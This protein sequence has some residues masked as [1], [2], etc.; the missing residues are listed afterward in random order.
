[1]A[2]AKSISSEKHDSKASPR[3]SKAGHAGEL[4][5]ILLGR[6]SGWNR[7]NRADG[8]VPFPVAVARS[9]R[10]L[11]TGAVISVL[12]IMVSLD[13]FLWMLPIA[14]GL[15]LSAPLIWWTSLT[16]AGLAARRSW[17]FLI[18]EESVARSMEPPEPP[19]AEPVRAA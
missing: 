10:H 3:P 12:A 17:L 9:T 4:L 15:L 18:P 5:D 6:D 13:T 14:L 8:V 16:S 19:P 11:V 2:D 1:M 7:Q